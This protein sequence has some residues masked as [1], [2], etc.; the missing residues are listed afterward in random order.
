MMSLFQHAAACAARAAKAVASETIA[1]TVGNTITP[2]I[3]AVIGRTDVRL[4]TDPEQVAMALRC[5]D[6][7]IERDEY[8][9]DDQVVT[10]KRGHKLTRGD[11]R[12][13]QVTAI[14][15]EPC[16]RPMSEHGTMLRIHAMEI[17]R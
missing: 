8:I 10:P 11:G 4:F 3:T 6:F 17:G 2:E 9:S 16:Y 1:L 12:I 5:L 7:Q 14:G 15:N 13:Y